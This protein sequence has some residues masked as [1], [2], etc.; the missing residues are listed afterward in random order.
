MIFFRSKTRSK[1]DPEFGT[2]KTRKSS[3]KCR[4][5]E[6]D[7]VS[8]NVF[9]GR[10]PEKVVLSKSHSYLG[11]T[12]VFEDPAVRNLILFQSEAIKN[13]AKNIPK[14]GMQK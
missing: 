1:I 3:K 4:R 8:E 10:F 7:S 5:N 12:E 6:P 14:K 2:Q 11:K 13:N 9:F